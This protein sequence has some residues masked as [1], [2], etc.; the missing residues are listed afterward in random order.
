MTAI[1]EQAKLNTLMVDAQ[2][3]A[4]TPVEFI[5]ALNKHPSPLNTQLIDNLTANVG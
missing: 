5:A 1:L 2:K 3:S 4:K